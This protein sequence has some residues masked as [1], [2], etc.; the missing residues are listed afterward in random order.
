MQNVAEEKMNTC[1]YD[2][3]IK[4]NTIRKNYSEKQLKNICLLC[5]DNPQSWYEKHIEEP[6][7]E[8]VKLLRN[9]GINTTCSCGHEM[10][11][12]CETY[13]NYY[14]ESNGVF[15]LLVGNGYKHFKIEVIKGIDKTGLK[16]SCLTIWL[17]KPNGELSK[18]SFHVGSGIKE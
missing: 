1:I 13:G 18:Y 9:N 15:N 12:E 5:K 14:D 3:K 16:F 11:C 17:P 10:Y 8:L 7:R 6:I 2:S 4:C